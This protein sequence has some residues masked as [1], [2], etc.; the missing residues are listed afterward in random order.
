MKRIKFIWDFR[1]P[2]GLHT[3]Q[4]HQIHLREFCELEKLTECDTG[5][6]A[7]NEAHAVAYLIAADKHLELVRD[8]LRPHRAVRA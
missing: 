5:H 1:G 8:R 6:E 4:H 2:S 7:I 3:A